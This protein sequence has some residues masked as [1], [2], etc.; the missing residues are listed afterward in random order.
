MRRALSGSAPPPRIWLAAAHR[1]YADA[2]RLDG[3]RNEAVAH[4]RRYLALAPAG[5]IDR[6][7]VRRTLMDMGEV[8]GD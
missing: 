6:A 7:D 4:Y 5:D 8:P 2:L 1:L 3:R